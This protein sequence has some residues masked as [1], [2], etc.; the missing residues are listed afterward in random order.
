MEDS[1]FSAEPQAVARAGPCHGLRERAV[2][3]ADVDAF[4]RSRAGRRLQAGAENRGLKAAVGNQPV[5][6]ERD[7]Y[8]TGQPVQKDRHADS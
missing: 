8:P 4:L 6:P 1:R 7:P 5:D 2:A 3:D